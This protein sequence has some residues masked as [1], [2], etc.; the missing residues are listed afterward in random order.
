MRW[1]LCYIA[2]DDASHLIVPVAC[3][4]RRSARVNG[5]HAGLIRIHSLAAQA[6]SSVPRVRGGDPDRPYWSDGQD[7][8]SPRT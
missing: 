8:C 3:P 4:I 5:G 1:S 2:R 7:N 6:V